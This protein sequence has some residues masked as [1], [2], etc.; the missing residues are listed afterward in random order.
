MKSKS[1]LPKQYIDAYWADVEGILVGKH[2][3]SHPAARAAIRAFRQRFGKHGGITLY[4][5]DPAEIAETIAEQ[6]LIQDFGRPVVPLADE[7]VTLVRWAQV[8]FAARCA[9][10]VQGLYRYAWPEAKPEFINFVNNAVD[11]A[12]RIAAE[13]K[14]DFMEM[15]NESWR[16][17]SGQ[18]AAQAAVQ[19][20]ALPAALAA[21]AAFAASTADHLHS[22]S[23]AVNA[24]VTSA[25]PS[26]PLNQHLGC[27]RRDFG[28]LQQT[29]RDEEW[30]NETLV[31][32]DVFGPMWPAGLAPEWDLNGHPKAKDEREPGQEGA[33]EIRE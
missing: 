24:I 3:A 29:A 2:Q 30:T 18:M 7:I 22:C 32:P 16:A 19:A 8:A 31:P 9:R 14:T 33:S 4:N 6:E 27:I 10:R 13:G 5:T 1:R 12:E 15:L 25:T 11:W 17:A 23:F 20:G 26:T 28:L 21:Q